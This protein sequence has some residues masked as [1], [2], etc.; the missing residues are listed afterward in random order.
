MDLGRCTPNPDISTHAD[1]TASLKQLP[2][3]VFAH[4]GGC[5]GWQQAG[6]WFS[7]FWLSLWVTSTIFSP[8]CCCINCVRNALGAE[9]DSLV[10]LKQ[11][12]A[13]HFGPWSKRTGRAA[14]TC[15]MV[16]ER[17]SSLLPARRD[18]AGGA[19]DAAARSEASD[20]LT[21]AAACCQTELIY[22]ASWLSHRQTQ[23]SVQALAEEIGKK[24]TFGLQRAY[25]QTRV[26][27]C[28]CAWENCCTHSKAFIPNFSSWKPP[29]LILSFGYI[30]LGILKACCWCF[31][32]PLF[33]SLNRV[34]FWICFK[35]NVAFIPITA[36]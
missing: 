29:P 35:M 18:K 22:P 28:V 23:L 30:K 24:K 14:E 10:A 2:T 21:A 5:Q 32:F 34:L 19:R 36:S 9:A 16:L 17:E 27:A 31:F 26:H 6:S 15:G 11:R 3:E 33:F 8:R 13:Q 4:W 7:L 1:I 12:W 25:K 20:V